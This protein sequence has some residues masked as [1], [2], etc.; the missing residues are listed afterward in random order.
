MSAGLLRQASYT[1]TRLGVYRTLED[2]YKKSEGTS[3]SFTWR[4]L[5]GMIAGGVGALVGNP[6]EITLVRMT[7][8]GRLPPSERRGYKNAFEALYRISKEEGITTLWRGWQPTVLRAMVLNA[9]QLAVYS[10]SKQILLQ[11]G[12]FIVHYF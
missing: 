10:Q 12:Y 4:L 6:S 1:T 5:F 3:P 9:A 7:S 8:D 2:Q 11:T